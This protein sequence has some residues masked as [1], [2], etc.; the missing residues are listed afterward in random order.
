MSNVE[1]FAARAARDFGTTPPPATEPTSWA[2]V[3]LTA[4]LNGDDIPPPVHLTRVD[5]ASLIYPGRTHQFAGES[6]SCKSWAA[7]LAV[8]HVL[9]NGGNVL[10]IDYEDDENGIVAR[11]RALGVAVPV[12]LERFTYV[13]PEEPIVNRNG[14][15]TP[16]GVDFGL[17]LKN[18]Y[19]LAIIDG[20]TEAMATEGFDLM[21][22][23][24]V[25][26]WM[27][28]VPKAIAT[29]TG[30]AVIAID[31]VPKSTENRGRYAIG[32]QHKLAGLSGAAY[33]F[34][35][36][37]PFNR[38]HGVDE[39]V[40]TVTITVVKDRPGHVRA[41]SFEGRAGVLELTSY[42]DGSVAGRVLSPSTEDAPSA[43]LLARIAEYLHQYPGSSK[44]RIETEVDGKADL[45]RKAL[46]WMAILP[47]EW[48]RIEQVGQSHRHYLTT[49]GEGLL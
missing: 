19:D 2:P 5:G 10:W 1:S 36:S 7:L 35:V 34:D 25:A 26:L 39:V 21:S 45:I 44:T 32:G 41:R 14:T 3:D 37:R 24:D 31:H 11:L 20:V 43:P 38:A 48:V 23:G 8:T 40:G 30:A 49:A 17:L 28:R 15:Y 27:R 22:N 29:F 16:A 12:I 46:R 6:E 18:T 33:R 42:A 47:R 4:A 13:R 9:D